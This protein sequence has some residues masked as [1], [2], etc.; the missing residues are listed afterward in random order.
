M[1][2]TFSDKT[3]TPFPA[4]K[5]GKKKIPAWNRKSEQCVCHSHLFWDGVCLSR[6]IRVSLRFVALFLAVVFHIMD[7]GAGCENKS[8]AVI[9]VRE[10]RNE[11]WQYWALEKRFRP[12]LLHKNTGFGGHVNWSFC[13]VIVAEIVFLKG[14]S[15]SL[16]YILS[17]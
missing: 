13:G 7:A 3:S 2:K 10:H 9:F 15:H 6:D 4:H 11:A 14:S 8:M 12:V 5:R 17:I 1:C 16:I